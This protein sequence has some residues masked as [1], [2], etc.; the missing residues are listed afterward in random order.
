MIGEDW[1]EEVA[2]IKSIGMEGEPLRTNLS[3]LSARNENN[4]E[5]SAS[6]EVKI[7]S[8]F[9]TYPVLSKNSEMEG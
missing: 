7:T 3:N 8:F 4:R 9:K 6:K 1:G 2:E 5:N